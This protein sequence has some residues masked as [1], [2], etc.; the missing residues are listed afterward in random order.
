MAILKF[1]AAC[2][3][4]ILKMKLHIALLEGILGGGHVRPW[5]FENFGRY[6]H[7][8]QHTWD[9]VAHCATWRR[10]EGGGGGL[11]TWNTNILARLY[12]IESLSLFIF[13]YFKCLKKKSLD[14]Q[15]AQPL[16]PHL[17][18][19]LS[20]YLCLNPSFP[21]LL[22]TCLFHVGCSYN[23]RIIPFGQIFFCWCHVSK[24]FFVSADWCQKKN[25]CHLPVVSHVMGKKSYIRYAS[26]KQ[27]VLVIKFT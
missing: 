2:S 17:P 27:E 19:P 11:I 16:M 4:N 10:F 6:V 8:W 15:H 7:P 13:F 24:A 3:R 23:E 26:N 12:D 20:P 5:Q 21:S 25:Q 14:F 1:W 22:P 18:L 9:E